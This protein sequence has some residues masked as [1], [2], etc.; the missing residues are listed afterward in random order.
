MILYKHFVKEALKL[1]L[2][3]IIGLLILLLTMRFA[4]YLGDAASGK[5]AP[6]YVS[7]I[8]MIKMLISL[9]DLI[10]ISLFLGT[11]A[12]MT[13]L[14][15]SSEWVSMRAA[16]IS[17][18]SMMRR[19]LMVSTAASILVAL[20]TFELSPKAE[21]NLIQLKEDGKNNASIA[22]IKAESFTRL[23]GGTKIFYAQ[24]ESEDATYLENT[25]V[26]DDSTPDDAIMS[27][28]RAYVS[29]EDDGQRTV[30]FEN[31]TSYAGKP[32]TLNYVITDFSSYNTQV[33][34]KEKTNYTSYASFVPTLSLFDGGRYYT[35]ELHWR[36][37]PVISA[38]L[39][40]I[41][42]LMIA[43]RIQGSKWYLSLIIGLSIFFIYQNCLGVVRSLLRNG[44]LALIIGLWPVHLIFILFLA[45]LYK[46]LQRGYCLKLG[47]L[48]V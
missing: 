5:V 22:G 2:L 38:L 31:G 42:A 9:K 3:I 13:R 6:E 41:L 43:M 4:S 30:V 20:I 28:N 32:G 29:T 35:T 25:F 46:H 16:G 8:V 44:D 47:K 48:T 45:G 40:P 7:K 1:S 26:H 17:T 10:P 21:L 39:T 19:L 12:T 18:A 37:A 11:F 14:Q 27:A 15:Q 33:K 36:L 23:S 34:Q 24:T